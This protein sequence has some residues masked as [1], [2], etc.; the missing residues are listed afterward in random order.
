[1]GPKDWMHWRREGLSTGYQ[2]QGCWNELLGGRT[3]SSARGEALKTHKLTEYEKTQRDGRSSTILARS[4]SEM[5]YPPTESQGSEE[6]SQ[7]GWAEFQGS[8]GGGRGSDDGPNMSTRS[9]MAD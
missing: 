2:S 9:I 7:V 4:P 1:M 8:L 6:M 5:R 3:K